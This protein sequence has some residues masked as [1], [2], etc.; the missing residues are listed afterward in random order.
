MNAAVAVELCG[1]RSRERIRNLTA[2]SSFR[3]LNALSS[4]VVLWLRHGDASPTAAGGLW[5]KKSELEALPCLLQEFMRSTSTRPFIAQLTDSTLVTQNHAVGDSPSLALSHPTAP[6]TYVSVSGEVER[7]AAKETSRR[8]WA[9]SLRDE[10]LHVFAGPARFY[11]VFVDQNG[12]LSARLSAHLFGLCEAKKN[13][14]RL[15]EIHAMR[16]EVI[17]AEQPT[18]FD[19]FTFPNTLAEDSLDIELMMPSPEGLLSPS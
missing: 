4:V 12:R 18:T 14:L 11:P 10:A 15:T 16:D 7:Q 6:V 19:H 2:P 8:V 9:A 17:K 13:K 5:L 3:F 1:R